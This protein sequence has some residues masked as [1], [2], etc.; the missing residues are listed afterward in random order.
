MIIEYAKFIEETCIKEYDS[1]EDF[2]YAL[3]AQKFLQNYEYHIEFI[4]IPK[5]NTIIQLWIFGR[6][7]FYVKYRNRYYTDLED[8]EYLNNRIEI[9]D[10]RYKDELKQLGSKGRYDYEIE[11]YLKSKF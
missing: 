4:D 1:D 9:Q 5:S 7:T 10:S 6:V 11:D 2:V 8:V 3:S